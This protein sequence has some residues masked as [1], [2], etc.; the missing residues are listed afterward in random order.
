MFQWI[1]KQARYAKIRGQQKKPRNSIPSPNSTQP[2]DSSAKPR[3]DLAHVSER[4]DLPSGTPET[5]QSTLAANEEALRG[6]A[7]NHDSVL[8]RRFQAGRQAKRG[9]MVVAVSGIVDKAV[10]NELVIGPLMNTELPQPG[11]G[12][13]AFL[14]DSVLAVVDIQATRHMQLVT[15]AMLQ[16]NAALFIE[17]EEEALLIPAAAWKTR[18]IEQPLSETV[19]R[20]P[21][22]SFVE[23][24]HTNLS[25]LRRRIHHPMLHMETVVLGTMTQTRIVLAY[26]QGIMNEDILEEMRRRLAG[27]KVDAILET[28]YIEQYIEDAPFSLFPTIA[29]TEKP[30]IVAARILEGR[31]AIFV[32]GTPIVMT[33]PDLLISH[34]Q[35]SE[36]YYARPFYASLMRLLRIL[37]FFTTIM[38]PGLFLAVQYYHPILIPY[39]LLVSLAKAREGVPFQLY[40]E[41]IV[42][43]LVFEVIREAGIRMPRP[44]GQ[45]ISIVGAIILGQAA[46]EAGLV[47]LPVVVVVAFAGISTFLVNSLVEPISILRLI[48]AIA[49]ASLGIYGILLLGMIVVTHLASLRSFGIPYA[50]PLFPIKWADWKDTILRMPL[51]LQWKRP[52]VLRPEDTIRQKRGGEA[53]GEPQKK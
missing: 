8:F 17:G 38:L 3:T 53:D 36:D 44:I 22:D 14:Q 21:R 13:T 35:V 40:I 45:A 1:G 48:F 47:G 42:M 52:A 20:G 43:I 12:T 19:I 4:L 33:A 25:L 39:S 28:G 15:E 23:D 18:A 5:V 37:S 24:L 9:V 7:G 30:D 27:I 16:G 51:R 34:F 26:I 31:V 41:V 29:N 49:G 10:L 46:V 6:M 11:D 2:A 32:D 50:A